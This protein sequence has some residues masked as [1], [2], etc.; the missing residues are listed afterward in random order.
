MSKK[1]TPGPWYIDG[2]AITSH[3]YHRL[4]C[5][6]EN[7]DTLA[8][9]KLI[10]AAPEL[11]EALEQVLIEYDEVDLAYGEPQSF[12]SAINEARRVIAKARGEH[13]Q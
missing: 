8:N 9:A 6:V 11:L 5:I 2:P 12:T 10:A 7:V 13:K 4:D 3:T 1:H